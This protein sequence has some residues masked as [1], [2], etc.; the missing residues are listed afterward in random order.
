MM[1]VRGYMNCMV[2]AGDSRGFSLIEL[3]ITIVI[4]GLVA[5]SFSL[6]QSHLNANSGKEILLTKSI[7]LAEKKMEEAIA[8]GVSVQSTGWNV[9]DELDWRR[10]VTVLRQSGSQPTLVEVRVDVRKNDKIIYSLFT[11]IADRG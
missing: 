11:H 1:K 6:I 10:T 7:V 9:E 8:E 2:P 4:F 3:V 5:Y